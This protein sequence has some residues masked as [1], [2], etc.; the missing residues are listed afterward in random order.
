[1]Y[2]LQ[3]VGQITCSMSSCSSLFAEPATLFLGDQID[4][5]HGFV[6]IH[7]RRYTFSDSFPDKELPHLEPQ[8]TVLCKYSSREET[9]PSSLIW[10]KL[11]GMPR[12][13]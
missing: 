8:S 3:T 6:S 4:H 9:D 11:C 5:I 2:P 10:N 12:N 13:K 7:Q 1:M